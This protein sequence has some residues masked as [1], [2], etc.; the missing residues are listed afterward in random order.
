MLGGTG[1]GQLTGEILGEFSLS[2]YYCARATAKRLAAPSILGASSW[3][4]GKRGLAVSLA[5]LVFIGHVTGAQIRGLSGRF[6]RRTAVS[7]PRRRNSTPGSD[8]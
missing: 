4:L 3:L 7:I 2:S 6:H 8:E 1:G 5:I